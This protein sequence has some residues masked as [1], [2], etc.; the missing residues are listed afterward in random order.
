MAEGEGTPKKKPRKTRRVGERA[1]PATGGARSAEH[2]K[3]RGKAR[4]ASRPE[5]KAAPQNG[6][7]EWADIYDRAAK[8][9]QD[10]ADQAR[11][12]ANRAQEA[13][14]KMAVD[15]GGGVESAFG[16]IR[17]QARD[18]MSKGQHT[19]VR[20]KFRNKQIAEVPIAVV[21]AAEVA[22]FW[23]FGPLRVVLGHVVG[24]A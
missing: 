4:K 1:S 13:A 18:L 5:T 17:E 9:L 21:A 14:K 15:L 20:I 12:A 8:K 22:T 11:P 7:A 10:I 16:K 2:P 24:K 3:N 23:W 19:R 6:D